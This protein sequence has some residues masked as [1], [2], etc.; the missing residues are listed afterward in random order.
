[1]KFVK[2]VAIT[3]AITA[4]LATAA[5]PVQCNTIL[6]APDKVF[7]GQPFAAR[8]VL[9]EGASSV[10]VAWLGKEAPVKLT[11]N[12]AFVLLGSDIKGGKAGTKT[13]LLRFK[14]EDSEY[15][16]KKEIKAEN[17]K[18]PAERLKVAPKMVTPPKE[19]SSRIRLE[20]ERSRKAIQTVSAG[21]AP[22]LPLV[23]PVPGIILSVYGKSRYFNNEFRGRH[24]GLDFRAPMGTPIKAVADGRVVETGDFWFAGKCVFIDHGAGLVSFYCHMSKVNVRPGLEVKAG[25]VIGLTGKSGRVTGPHLHMSL[26]WRGMFFDPAPLFELGENQLIL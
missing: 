17:K 26:S 2:F 14:L 22:R 6:D 3:A 10:K 18:Y 19:V 20:S 4:F 5:L 21:A 13:L 8:I 25:E 15:S 1:L 12:K 23:R 9:P 24:G 16:I 7:I 11:G